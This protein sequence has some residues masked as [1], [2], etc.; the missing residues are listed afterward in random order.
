MTRIVNCA[1]RYR[2]E[3]CAVILA[4]LSGLALCVCDDRFTM[5][6]A[7]IQEEGPPLDLYL[8]SVTLSLQPP[9]YAM[10]LTTLMLF[11]AYRWLYANVKRSALRWMIPSA[12]LASLTLLLADS[13]FRDS[14]W[15]SVIR[16]PA[17]LTVSFIKMLG[18]SG[19]IVIL[20]TLLDRLSLKPAEGRLG[21]MDWR[22]I[23]RR[24]LVLLALW[25]PYI[26]IMYPATTNGDTRDQVAQV[27]GI[28]KG[29]VTARSIVLINPDVILNNH[30]PV[31]HTAL[32]GL[33]VR[34]GQ[35]IGSLNAGLFL[36]GALQCVALAF[37]LSTQQAFIERHCASG[38]F[39]TASLLFMALNPLFPLWGMTVVKDV[40]FAILMWWVVV[41]FWRQLRIGRRV[42]VSES[43]LFVLVLLVW[44]LMRNNG[45]YVLLL[46][47]PCGVIYFRK[48]HRQLI[49]VLD[50]LLI[51]MV[52]FQGGVQTVL[53]SALDIT[54]GSPREAL[55]VPFMQTA[56]MLTYHTDELT[57]EEASLL[58]TLF[59]TTDGDLRE[60]VEK[61]WERPDRS[62][63]VKDSF[64]KYTGNKE[65]FGYLRL[66]A[67]YLVKHPATYLQA[68]LTLVAGW[69]GM[70]SN[71]DNI[72]YRCGIY[73]TLNKMLPEFETPEALLPF[74]S[75]LE[76]IVTI[77]DSAPFIG[78][79][80][81]MS[82]YTWALLACLLFMLKR[83]KKRE[84]MAMT[85]LICNY[86]VCF[87]GP[88]AYM[89]YALPTVV[90]L[91]IIVMFAFTEA[92]SP[93][94]RQDG[95]AAVAGELPAAGAP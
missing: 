13:F 12:M 27:L 54:P 5:V 92:K 35:A 79:L 29:C 9:T 85:P 82:F 37:T 45:Y 47:F 42:K 58:A 31:A 16:G 33:F 20:L 46:V 36:M 68:H 72:Y 88:V 18:L 60:L 74:R 90:C 63:T 30:H 8:E 95:P 44:M 75:A 65:L 70:N 61:Y 23:C 94:R 69:F 49:R 14:T 19:M 41:L 64:N 6:K 4:S 38:K 93:K 73:P 22:A 71:H 2:R 26:V 50:L 78:W 24:A 7:L 56:R 39:R 10:A 34:L 21:P 55:S 86:V 53:F 15:D 81:E 67:K 84:L 17:M 62:D 11:F 91:P 52:L 32:M 66:W 80:L 48:H 40:P 76:S 87:L 89:R 83:R 28:V 51:A 57:G 77:L 1:K 25:L 43:A 59:E 3:I